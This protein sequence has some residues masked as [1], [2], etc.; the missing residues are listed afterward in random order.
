M[1]VQGT[2]NQEPAQIE[3][4]RE[5]EDGT[6]DIA[7]RWDITEETDTDPEM[8]QEATYWD[9][10]KHVFEDVELNCPDAAVED[11][12]QRRANSLIKKAK[13]KEG[14]LTET[15]K[16]NLAYPTFEPESSYYGQ[17]AEI[18]VSRSDKKYLRVEKTISGQTI[19]A[20]CFV[21]YSLLLAHQNNDLAIGDYVVISFVD[22]DLD[23]PFAQGKVVGF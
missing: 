20:W 14:T 7:V 23:K 2:Q 6:V 16:N 11:Y 8:G 5:H 22:E 10:E 19:S 13:A 4:I 12:L 3:K 21:D 9:Y 18:D 17:I 1:K 15:D